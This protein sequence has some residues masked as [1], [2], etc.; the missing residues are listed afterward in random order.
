MISLSTPDKTGNLVFLLRT[1]FFI[2]IA[3]NLYIYSLSADGPYIV[4]DFP[5]LVENDSLLIKDLN[6]D[7]LKAAAMSSPA[8]RYH[9]PL[10]MLTFAANYSLAGNTDPY[11]VKMTNIF[12]HIITGL[13]IY[14]L[15]LALMKRKSLRGDGEE[16]LNGELI[17][18]LTAFLWLFHPLFVSTVLYAVQR[19]AMLSTFFVIIGCLYYCRMRTGS[20]D[21]NKGFITGSALI[22]LITLM[23][24]FSKENGA[25]LPGFLLLIEIFFF[26]FQFHPDTSRLDKSL[27]LSLLV[28]PT[29]FIAGYLTFAYLR[30]ADGNA[31]TYFFTLHERLLTQFR[32]LWH[33]IGW[34]T[35]TNPEPMAIYHDDFIVSGSLF[36]PITT[37]LSLLGFIAVPLCLIKIFHPRH[38]SLFCFLWFLWGHVLESTVLPLSLMFEHRNYLPGYGILLGLSILIAAFARQKKNT[39]LLKALVF[40]VV[41][42]IPVYILYE[43]VRE[44]DNIQSFTLALLKNNPQSPNVYILAAKYLEKADDYDNAMNAIHIADQLKTG[45]NSPIIAETAIRC[46]MKPDLEFDAEFRNRLMHI[47]LKETSLNEQKHL[48]RVAEVCA[49]SPKNFSYLEE[50]YKN[51]ID[52]GK[53]NLAAIAYYGMGL[54]YAENGDYAATIKAWE[55]A[56]NTHEVAKQLIPQLEKMKRDY[57]KRQRQMTR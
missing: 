41:F 40:L 36:S 50:L 30:S 49:L 23:A 44:W 12:L 53:K 10:S 20:L 47:N 26:N 16:R 57:E 46:N 34:L 18:F 6:W 13:G 31:G 54:I 27:L 7:S 29:C 24:F 42:T 3:L 9:R 48:L 39:R 32:A 25:L 37:L 38:I 33:Y 28:V 15:T 51:I 52:N 35:F 55:N 43:R 5:N 45:G 22:V 19:M 56:I 4:D 21:R 8:S 14:L 17:A 11:P 1:V 2:L